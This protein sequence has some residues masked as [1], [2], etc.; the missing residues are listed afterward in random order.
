M[1][2]SEILD[3]AADLIEQRGHA[4]RRHV[5]ASGCLC[6]AGAMFAA[7]GMEPDHKQF[8]TERWAG[9]T[10]ERSDRVKEVFDWFRSWLDRTGIDSEDPVHWNDMQAR[11]K[12]EVVSTLRRAAEAAR[13]S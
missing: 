12:A 4:K 13:V 6:A 10:P 7:V 5:T 1:N 11:S 8:E 3:K 9:Y 2:T